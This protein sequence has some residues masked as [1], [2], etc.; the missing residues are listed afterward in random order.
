MSEINMEDSNISYTRDYLVKRAYQSLSKR[1]RKKNKFIEPN[2]I[3]KDRKTYITNFDIFCKSIN[4]DKYIVKQYIDKETTISSSLLCESTQLKIDSSL[5]PS[6]VK[7]IITIYI[8]LYILCQ[9]CKS[10]DTE[11]LHKNRLLFTFCN[12]CKSERIY[13]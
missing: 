2:I 13:E 11:L 9:E 4:R 10:S 1:E 5:K 6:H 8:K 12:Y 7:N 3:V